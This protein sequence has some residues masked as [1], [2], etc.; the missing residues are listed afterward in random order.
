MY[1]LDDLDKLD[2]EIKAMQNDIM[3]IWGFIGFLVIIAV[4]ILVYDIKHKEKKHIYMSVLIVCLAASFAL[5]NIYQVHNREMLKQE[6]NRLIKDT[7]TQSEMR[8]ANKEICL[9]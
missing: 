8:L 1:G 2:L 6:K 7:G 4:A 3:A 9:H 5:V